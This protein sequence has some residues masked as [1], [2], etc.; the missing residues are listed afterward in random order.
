MIFLHRVESCCPS[1]SLVPGDYNGAGWQPL[2]G[3]G[4]L[5]Q[6][7]LP[8]RLPFQGGV[9]FF[10]RGWGLNWFDG[11]CPNS[12]Q[13]SSRLY[14]SLGGLQTTVHRTSVSTGGNMVGTWNVPSN[15]FGI[16]CV[17]W[18]F[19]LVVWRSTCCVRSLYWWYRFIPVF[20]E[21]F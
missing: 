2:R 20:C 17:P 6:H 4:I 14:G 19:V 15:C 5:S 9:E 11:V 1:R 12:L 21:V 3:R 18:G 7:S 10:S 16:Y 13:R 8:C